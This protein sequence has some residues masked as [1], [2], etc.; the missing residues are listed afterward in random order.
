MS[1]PRQEQLAKASGFRIGGFQYM[2]KQ[3]SLDGRYSRQVLVLGEKAQKK[4][5]KANVA[6]L[7]L[8]A[9]GTV[10]AEL[11]C[12]AGV[13]SLLLIDRDC[14]EESNL[15]RQM[16]Y[17][18]KDVGRA[19]AKAAADA[20]KNINSAITIQSIIDDVNYRNIATLLKKCTLV[21]DCTDNLYTRFLLNEFCREHSIPWIYAG[22]IRKVGNVM[23]ILPDTPCFACTFAEMEQTDTCDT[24][25]VL[26]T[27]TT[28][29]AALQAQLALQILT[30]ACREQKLI[31]IDLDS[32]RIVS[33]QTRFSKSCTVC[34]GKYPYLKGEREP[35]LLTYQ[36]SGLY[37]FSKNNINL[38]ELASRL[39]SIGKVTGDNHHLF[40]KNISA[41]SSGRIMIKAESKKHAKST[42]ARYIGM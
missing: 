7:G 40:F 36:C 12:R 11:L 28:I 33:L 31:R 5:Q 10:A 24:V 20:L 35:S 34:R 4:L 13:G 27:A 14:V 21:L 26:N 32:L 41:F 30:G 39:R 23:V 17:T 9:L 22:A 1:T 8:G 25:G 6:V 19:K 42:L 29:V 2:D 37:V 38:K 18:E 15:Q 16:L 3:D